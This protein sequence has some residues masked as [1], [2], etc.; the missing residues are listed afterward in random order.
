MSRISTQPDLERHPTE[1]SRIA[2]H[3][4][5][6]VA[7]VGRTRSSRQ[8]KDPLPPFGAGKPYPRCLPAQEEYVVE[9]DGENDPA[10]PHNWPLKR[11]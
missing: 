7:T 10:H 5:Q 2:T 3:R 8:C 11:K 6:H 1:L 4:S 9:F